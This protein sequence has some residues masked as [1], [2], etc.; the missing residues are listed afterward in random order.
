MKTPDSN[1]ILRYF[2]LLL[3]FFQGASGLFGGTALVLDPTG[4]Y[5]GLP[6]FFLEGT[7]FNNYLYPGLILLSVL[8]AFPMAVF[9]GLW[10]RQPWSWWGAL[11]TGIALIIWLGVEIIMIGYHA[12]PPLQLIYGVTGL[13][14]TLFAFQAV[15]WKNFKP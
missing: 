7:P 8:G 1:P 14:I 2:L 11:L 3:L 15:Y 9:Y 12:D 4:D 13:L 5:L 6:L 10:K